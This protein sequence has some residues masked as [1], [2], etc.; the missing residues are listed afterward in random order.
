MEGTERDSDTNLPRGAGLQKHSHK[1]WTSADPL[2]KIA[3][4]EKKKTLLNKMH[5]RTEKTRTR[6]ASANTVWC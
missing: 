6:E 2:K 3:D 1:E 4:R 5:T